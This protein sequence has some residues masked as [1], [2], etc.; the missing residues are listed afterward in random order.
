MN[1][2]E[3]LEVVIPAYNAA[4]TIGAAVDS[5]LEVAHRV[6][7]V[8]DGSDDETAAVAA[9][10]G[11][12]VL[13]QANAGAARARERGVA[14]VDAPFVVMLDADDVL[15]VDG[16]RRSVEILAADSTVAVA[17]GRVV[18]VTPGGERRLLPAR[19]HI[20]APTMVRV[21]YGP[22][23]PAAQ[24]IR[25]SAYRAAESI[26]PP[27]LRP[28]F[29]EDFELLIRLSMVGRVVQHDIP[30]CEY[31]LYV[32]KSARNAD[33]SLADKEAIRAAYGRH[34]GVPHATMGSLRVRSGVAMRASRAAAASGDRVRA[35]RLSFTGAL[36]RL[37]SVVQGGRL[38]EAAYASRRPLVVVPWLEGG[39]AQYALAQTMAKL[40]RPVDVVVLF[41]GSRDYRAVEAQ[42]ASFVR[43]DAPR[44][45]IG[46]L[47]AALRLRAFL[48]HRPAVFSLLRGSHLVLGL[49]VGKARGAALGASFHQLPST[50]SQDR[51][52]R[53]EDVLVR[54]YTRRCELVTA[55]SELAV[56]ELVTQGFA[57]E[58][59]V[60]YSPNLIADRATAAVAPRTVTQPVRL[61]M[62][63]RLAEQKGILDLEALLS[64]ITTPVELRIVGDGELRDLVEGLARRNPAVTLV[65]RVEDVNPHYDWCDAV[66]M[67]SRYEL[68]PIVVW[69]A[70]ASGR[71]VIGSDI[72][73]FR[74]LASAGPLRTFRD[75]A[76]LD[77]AVQ[78]MLEAG[79]AQDKFRQATRA[80]ESRSADR[81]VV[82]FLS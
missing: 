22:W 20:D 28:R 61:L 34:L 7:V 3:D 55:P 67:P 42:A 40:A 48:A 33:A 47:T 16:V 10:H 2:R 60:R 72:E 62:A 59:V 46:V 30:S 82:D 36:L 54:R 53:A 73:V 5:A 29:A 26:D 23:P 15:L 8:D 63:G 66:F 51:L 80:F 71:P 78:E 25:T 49:V 69:E 43:L 14:H 31:A 74:D 76:Q 18:A 6:V 70:W 4:A 37:A 39:G 77:E 32:G 27:R 68:N 57:S 1:A 12:T 64:D 79:E 9:R 56:D 21:G 58:E 81:T 75:G 13:T 45:P 35:L 65:G 24:V 52:A 38:S 19:T 11:A 50:D 17:A 44:S 41:A